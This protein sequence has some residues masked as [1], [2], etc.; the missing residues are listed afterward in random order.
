VAARAPA[1]LTWPNL[2]LTIA[3]DPT[4]A[5]LVVHTPASSLCVE[6]QT[7]WPN[8]PALEGSA[9]ERSGLRTLAPGETLTSSMSMTVRRRGEAAAASP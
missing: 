3:W 5:T 2:E 6:P 8:A 1:V 7:A 9:R 4:P